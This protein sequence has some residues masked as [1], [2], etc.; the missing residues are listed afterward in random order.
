MDPLVYCPNQQHT[1]AEGSVFFLRIAKGVGY[2]PPDPVG[3][4]SDVN[5][6]AW[7]AGWVEAAYDEG[8]LSACSSDPLQFC[9]DQPLNR[10]WAA[11]MMVQ[12]KDGMSAP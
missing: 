12:A 7:Y 8:I 2:Q 10:A 5:I 4:F 11:Y 9:P 6:N 1:R 3:I